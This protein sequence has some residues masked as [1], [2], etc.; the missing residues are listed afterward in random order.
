MGRRTQ[1][2]FTDWFR[3][4]GIADI[5]AVC[6]RPASSIAPNTIEVE[7]LLCRRHHLVNRVPAGV[8]GIGVTAHLHSLYFC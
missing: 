6:A 2:T 4:L 5:E 8:S 3:R 7:D 1:V